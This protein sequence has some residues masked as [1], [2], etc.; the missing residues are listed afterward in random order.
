MTRT[1]V[2]GYP[3]I[4]AGRELKKALERYWSSD[5]DETSLRR[6]AARIRAA[7]W[8]TQASAGIDII[9]SGDFSLYDHVLDTAAM[10][11]VVPP[12][13]GAAVERGFGAAVPREPGGGR[14]PLALAAYFAM[15]RGSQATS[16]P[17]MSAAGRDLPALEMTKW[18]DTNYHYIVP[19]ISVGQGFRFAFP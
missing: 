15:A 12:R 11:G 19:E 9:P 17:S 14:E 7:H 16:P 5:I 4:G 2:L 13:Y 10:V 18:F 3:R 1:A 8:K 6:E